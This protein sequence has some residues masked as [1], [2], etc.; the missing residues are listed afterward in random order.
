M[1]W[2]ETVRPEGAVTESEPVV[3]L[4]DVE[5]E[6]AGVE[7]SGLPHPSG[8]GLAR[9]PKRGVVQRLIFW[10]CLAWLTLAAL[11]ALFAS[12]LP[13]PPYSEMVGQ[14]LQRPGLHWPE[15]LGTD[16]LG[17]SV[18]SRVIDGAQVSL[19]VGLA[20]TALSLALGMTIGMVAGFFRGK[21]EAVTDILVDAL[22]AFP[23]LILLL[24]MTSVLT[25]SIQ[26]LVVA[27]T[28]LQIPQ[29]VRVTRVN[30]LAVGQQ[31]YVLAARTLGGG[32]LRIIFRE[33]FPNV[34]L[35]V[36]SLAFIVAAFVIVAEGSLSFLGL[37]VPAPQPSWGG[38]I[39]SGVHQLS[40]APF[41]V[42][43][44]ALALFFTVFSLNTLGDHARRRLDPR[45]GSL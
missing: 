43:I 29:F 5:E 17:R 44:P 40:R 11:M 21:V 4:P 30:V 1:S 2:H 27:L 42:A 15:P 25:P 33:I 38:M 36:M 14:P 12:F 28:L 32:R 3:L 20:T 7:P 35:Q 10:A 37:G 45:A 23:P 19:V 6:V 9:R 8:D 41:L 22:L 31:E 26:T 24:A 18:L 39:A 34:V 16:E 13:L